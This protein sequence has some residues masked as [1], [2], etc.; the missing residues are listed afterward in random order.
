[1]NELIN[2]WVSGFFPFLIRGSAKRL[3]DVKFKC[4]MRDSVEKKAKD[5]YVN[6]NLI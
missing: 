2:E 4:R 3:K 6:F 1:M 5:W